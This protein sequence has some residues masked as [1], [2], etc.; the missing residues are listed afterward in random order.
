MKDLSML[1]RE[2]SPPKARPASVEACP[3]KARPAS[4]EASPPKARPASVEAASEKKP[5]ANELLTNGGS[6]ALGAYLENNPNSARRMQVEMKDESMLSVPLMGKD[7]AAESR[8]DNSLTESAILPDT[9]RAESLLNPDDRSEE[10]ALCMFESVDKSKD[11]VLSHGELK[12]YIHT[13]EW[14]KEMLSSVTMEGEHGFHWSDFFSTY[15]SD[16]DGFI[17]I[18]EF[19]R[20]YHE[21]ILPHL[22]DDNIQLGLGLGLGLGVGLVLPHLEDDNTVSL[23]STLNGGSTLSSLS[24]GI[25]HEILEEKEILS[26]FSTQS[27]ISPLHSS[28]MRSQYRVARIKESA[29][30]HSEWI[31]RFSMLESSSL[32]F[33][34]LSTDERSEGELHR[35][36]RGLH[37]RLSTSRV[38][39]PIPMEAWLPSTH[40]SLHQESLPA[41]VKEAAKTLPTAGQ[42]LGCLG[43]SPAAVSAG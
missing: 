21:A 26:P 14:G 36:S 20:L 32:G 28:I 13:Q 7:A 18:E 5:S 19:T 42:C 31:P 38:S 25:P 3:P 34:L 33:L 8:G 11:G 40:L 27:N 43:L 39:F 30:L 15:D 9:L 29:Q 17:D 23:D 1:G 24:S 16:E 12:R 22:E 37:V 10:A 4:V 35:M 6:E 41:I 2:A